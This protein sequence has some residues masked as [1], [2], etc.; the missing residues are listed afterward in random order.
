MT[1]RPLAPVIPSSAVLS[2]RQSA[3]AAGGRPLPL[4]APVSVPA[5]PEGVVYGIGRIDASGRIA[6]RALTTALGWCGGDRLTL[7][8]DA[9]VITARRDPGG[10]ITLPGRACIAIPAVLRR[11]CGLRPGDR[12]LLAAVPGED[13]LTAYSLAV[14][15]Q[16]IRAH[17][18]F[19]HAQGEKS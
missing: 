8:A 13:T 16:A 17:G 7:T 6:D 10:M 11:R 3:R 5:P 15:D 14:V 2:G 4:A 1:A 19:P 9:G 12:V 18:S